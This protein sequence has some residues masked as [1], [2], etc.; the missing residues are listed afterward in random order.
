TRYSAE[1]LFRIAH[2]TAGADNDPGFD[3]LFAQAIGNHLLGIA[4]HWTPSVADEIERE[5]WLDRPAPSFGGVLSGLLHMEKAGKRDAPLSEDARV[6][7]EDAAD[8]A[9]IAAR[10]DVSASDGDWIVAHLTRGGALTAAEKS[11]LGFLKD[12]A[13]SLP[14]ALMQAIEAQAR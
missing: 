4:F 10:S 6:S 3:A 11:L 13:H 9:E 7:R 12:N 8:R 1:T 2:A 14:P 5:R